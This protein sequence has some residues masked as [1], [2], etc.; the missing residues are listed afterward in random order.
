MGIG[1]VVVIAVVV[2]EEFC[3]VW[4]VGAV[5]GPVWVP[6]VPMVGPTASNGPAGAPELLF[7]N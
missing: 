1:V 7:R 4:I 3:A 5:Y 2:E 6:P